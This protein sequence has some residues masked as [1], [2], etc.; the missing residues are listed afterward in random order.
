MWY[1]SLYIEHEYL[2]IHM[3]FMHTICGHYKL[4]AQQFNYGLNVLCVCLNKLVMLLN[5]CYGFA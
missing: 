3:N 5:E 2:G 4:I 1:N